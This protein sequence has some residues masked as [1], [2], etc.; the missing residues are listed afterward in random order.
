MNPVDPR[1][2]DVQVTDRW[3]R[4]VAAAGRPIAAIDGLLAA[5]ALH[6]VV[7]LSSNAPANS[8]NRTAAD[9]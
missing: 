3:G 4:M 9:R 1:V 7:W 2:V 8:C 6:H 5:T